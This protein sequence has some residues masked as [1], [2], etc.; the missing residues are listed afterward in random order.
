MGTLVMGLKRGSGGGYLLVESLRCVE[1]SAEARLCRDSEG[2][3]GKNR[4]TGGVRWNKK[5]KKSSS[6]HQKTREKPAEQLTGTGGKTKI[7]KRRSSTG[8]TRKRGEKGNGQSGKSLYEKQKVIF[9]ERREKTQRKERKSQKSKQGQKRVLG[10]MWAE[11]R[12][13]TKRR[14]RRDLRKRTVDGV[15]C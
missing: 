12:H 13:Q 5:G 7:G 6:Q 2:M 4:Q 14:L 8:G 3:G 15:L 9:E 10:H 1:R 11:E